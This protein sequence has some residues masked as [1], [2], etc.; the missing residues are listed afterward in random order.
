M[1]GGYLNEFLYYIRFDENH[2]LNGEDTGALAA[3]ALQVAD[4]HHTQCL[5]LPARFWTAFLTGKRRSSL[6]R[7]ARE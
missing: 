1:G 2:R 7:T 3:H 6:D 4:N 5:M